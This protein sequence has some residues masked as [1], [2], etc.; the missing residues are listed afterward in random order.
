MSASASV[1]RE[2]IW[3]SDFEWRP[4]CMK[5]P[6]MSEFIEMCILQKGNSKRKD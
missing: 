3:E 5:E 2:G 4:E 6:A 1:V